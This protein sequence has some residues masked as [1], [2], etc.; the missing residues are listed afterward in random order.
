MIC[1]NCG[2]EI[3]NE[4]VFCNKCGFKVDSII[5]NNETI[6]EPIEE[7]P[8]V[9]NSKP[10]IENDNKRKYIIIAIVAVVVVIIISALFGG[11]NDYQGSGN[12]QPQTEDNF[13]VNNQT[14]TQPQTTE[15][16]TAAPIDIEV[17]YPEVLKNGADMKAKV[18]DYKL[19]YDQAIQMYTLKVTFEK[20]SWTGNDKLDWLSF[21]ANVYAY[22]EAGNLIGSGMLGGNDFPQME[23]GEQ[24]SDTY[25]YYCTQSSGQLARIE[26]ENNN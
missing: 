15:P 24:F 22:D 10:I 4:S 19:S 20:V 5:E 7:N 16:I 13:G 26:L 3:S 6:R 9:N 2:N 21:D 11:G 18:V 14:V 17:V 1:K 23:V 8:I 25:H 12:N